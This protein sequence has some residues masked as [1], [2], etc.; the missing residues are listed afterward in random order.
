MIG[1]PPSAPDRLSYHLQGG[2]P[3][4]YDDWKQNAAAQE[5]WQRSHGTAVDDYFLDPDCLRRK[6][7]NRFLAEVCAALAVLCGILI[8]VL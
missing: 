6:R 7:R 3:A 5:L 8:F 1:G 4:K 2:D